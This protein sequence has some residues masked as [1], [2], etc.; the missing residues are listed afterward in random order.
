VIVGIGVDLTDIS[1][2]EAVLRRA[3]ALAARLFAKSE[4][5]APAASMAGSIAAK[6]AA[7][8]E[9]AAKEAAAKAP[10]GPRRPDG[11]LCVAMVAARG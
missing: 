6:E 2:L 4:L 9:A 3:H 11:G 7:A 1:R 8:K 10:G 5:G